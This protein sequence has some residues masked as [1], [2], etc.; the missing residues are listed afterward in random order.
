MRFVCKLIH[1]LS[2]PIAKSLTTS[3][4]EKA[5]LAGV[6][7]WQVDNGDPG[8]FFCC[9][10]PSNVEHAL[11]YQ[12]KDQLH[13][14]K[15]TILI[16]ERL[17]CMIAGCTLPLC[18]DDWISSM[19]FSQVDGD[20]AICCAFVNL[21]NVLFDDDAA[22]QARRERIYLDLKLL[23]RTNL[24][25][26]YFKNVHISRLFR[27]ADI[28]LD[29]MK[30]CL[31]DALSD[32]LNVCHTNGS[33]GVES[34][35]AVTT[36]GESLNTLIF[37]SE[38]N[39]K[40]IFNKFDHESYV[41]L[42][43]RDLPQ[44]ISGRMG[45]KT[46]SVFLENQSTIGQKE[47]VDVETQ[48]RNVVFEHMKSKFPPM[49]RQFVVQNESLYLL[50]LA[51]TISVAQNLHVD[52]LLDFPNSQYG[53]FLALNCCQQCH[54]CLDTSTPDFKLLP[55]LLNKMNLQVFRSSSY[56]HSGTSCTCD[57]DCKVVVTWYQDVVLL[58]STGGA[59]KYA[60][61]AN[62]FAKG[63]MMLCLSQI[64]SVRSC[65]GCR[66]ELLLRSTNL[67]SA[68]SDILFCNV[69]G[70][71]RCS[72][73]QALQI[74][75]Y[76]D[77]D[78]TTN[79]NTYLEKCQQLSLSGTS[80]CQPLCVHSM[81]QLRKCVPFE[82]LC[83]IFTPR[84][85]DNFNRN[86][87]NF[88]YCM[89]IYEIQTFSTVADI[90]QYVQVKCQRA[91]LIGLCIFCSL[92]NPKCTSV[93]NILAGEKLGIENLTQQITNL[94]LKTLDLESVKHQSDHVIML[95]CE[96]LGEGLSLRCSATDNADSATCA[97]G[98]VC[99][100]KKSRDYDNVLVSANRQV[101]KILGTVSFL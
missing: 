97:C 60:S 15:K 54:V 44:K 68:N 55:V 30:T 33:F 32:E 79:M 26:Y 80:E 96:C 16:C 22:F 11:I 21:E 98:L 100:A 38:G 75:K 64:P 3:N 20:N 77:D 85:I 41:F 36:V 46:F 74:R 34:V 39:I 52:N 8:K 58:Y 92:T 70:A 65:G 99:K 18:Q 81:L 49:L 5:E 63:Y 53:C 40:E 61:N 62:S 72:I 67:S 10:P 84:Q 42:P 7:G 69:C 2:E 31:M 1:S 78:H 71:Y 73:C 87:L 93:T 82:V 88:V 57:G 28:S 14:V 23:L 4:S 89:N 17:S 47:I 76:S 101:D 9:I 13:F 66:L 6:C 37:D 43:V 27:N 56:V 90:L 94:R 35:P 91:F 19:L 59:R 83:T 29:F 50:R 48:F 95:L 24:N 51:N 45:V 25:A 86:A 12:E